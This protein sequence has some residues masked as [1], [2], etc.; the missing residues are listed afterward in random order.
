MARQWTP[1]ALLAAL[2]AALLCLMCAVTN[3][4][5]DRVLGGDS[6]SATCREISRQRSA[7][8]AERKCEC[9]F[10]VRLNRSTMRRD[11]AALAQPGL[12]GTAA[13]GGI[14]GACHSSMSPLVAR[15]AG[16]M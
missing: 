15:A 13:P 3:A 11:S 1:A 14:V 8:C 4:G 6:L 7:C 12:A 16:G 2:V 9:S 5:S 10:R